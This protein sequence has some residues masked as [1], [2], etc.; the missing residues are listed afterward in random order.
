M[1]TL[2]AAVAALKSAPRPL[3]VAA[4]TALMLRSGWSTNSKSP[5]NIVRQSLYNALANKKKPSPIAKHGRGRFKYRAPAGAPA[6]APAVAAAA[7]PAVKPAVKAATKKRAGALRR[8][9][10]R[11]AG[12]RVSTATAVARVLEASSARRPMH[13]KD[14]T[15]IALE[16]NWLKTKS[17][18]PSNVVYMQIANEIRREAKGG[19]KTVFTSAGRGNF[20]L[21]S[22]GASAMSAAPV[23]RPRGR[24][25]G[26]PGRPRGR[27]AGRPTGRPVGRPAGRPVGRPA[28]RR[29]AGASLVERHN[30]SVYEALRRRVASAS[31]PM[32]ER[33]VRKLL[34]KMGFASSGRAS[35]DKGALLRGALTIGGALLMPLAVR[36]APRGA[37]VSAAFVRDMRGAMQMYENGVIFAAGE[38]SSDAQ[39]EASQAG[40]NPIS[41]I[42]AAALA[43]LLAKHGVGV[44][45]APESV[46]ALGDDF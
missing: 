39:A 8:G 14:I 17:K 45:A 33:G 11:P 43:R 24:P 31:G 1:K 26:R 46:L 25:A 13:Y 20:G 34:D 21:K 16:K 38:F 5:V 42:G 36:I 23:G 12:R 28:G 19:R 35:S 3:T 7:K 15:R 4:L 44:R 40:K 9:P 27:P 37:R 18:D 30:E 32:F 29:T 41:L 22:W 6:I 10:G 2:E